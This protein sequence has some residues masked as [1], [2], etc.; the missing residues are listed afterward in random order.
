GQCLWSLI[1]SCPPPAIKVGSWLLPSNRVSRYELPMKMP[2]RWSPKPE[3]HRSPFLVNGM[4]KS[5]ALSALGTRAW[6]GKKE[7]QT[8]EFIAATGH[9]GVDRQRANLAQ[10]AACTRCFR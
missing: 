10:F 6:Y 5:Y 3:A 7:R 8:H 2:G 9:P 1:R 4:V